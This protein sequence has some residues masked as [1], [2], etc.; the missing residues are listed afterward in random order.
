MQVTEILDF[1]LDLFQDPL[2]LIATLWII[3]IVIAVVLRRRPK[4]TKDP[5]KPK[6]LKTPKIKVKGHLMKQ[7]QKMTSEAEKD[8]ELTVPP[9]R[10]RQEIIT[11]MFEAKT[12]AIG[13]EASTASGYVP[14]SHTPLAR[15]LKER[16]VP[17]DIISAIIAGLME[18]ENEDDVKAIIEAAADSPEVN[19][20]GDELRKAKE[21]AVEEWRNVKASS[22]V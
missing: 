15:F 17:E 14:M 2:I 16:N 4:G 7:M 9:V 19:L 5:T 22:D 20:I 18:E 6:E 13:L 10:S 1:V 3:G 21:L 12:R 11:Q 8:K